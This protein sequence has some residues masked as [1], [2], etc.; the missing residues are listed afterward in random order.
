MPRLIAVLVGSVIAIVLVRTGIV[1][2]SL[3]LSL[4][5]AALGGILGIMI[6]RFLVGPM[7]LTGGI[8]GAVLGAAVIL[9]LLR[10]AKGAGDD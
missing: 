7:G 8:I 6:L 9:V 10:R 2:S 1:T 5:Y 3:L 4:A